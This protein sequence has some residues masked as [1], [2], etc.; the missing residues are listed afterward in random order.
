[1]NTLKLQ[2]KKPF[3]LI[4]LLI[5]QIIGEQHVPQTELT[6]K[7]CQ[8]YQKS[9]VSLIIKSLPLYYQPISWHQFVMVTY[10]FLPYVKMTTC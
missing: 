9:I 5:K 1:M 6:L 2:K 4:S 8:K 3:L 7:A 10:L